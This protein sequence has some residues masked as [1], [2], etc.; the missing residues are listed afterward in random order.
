MTQD[1]ALPLT[2]FVTFG[3]PFMLTELQCGIYKMETKIP[4]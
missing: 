1:L 4:H 2:S 3:I